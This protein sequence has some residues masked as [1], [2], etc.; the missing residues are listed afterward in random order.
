MSKSNDAMLDALRK[1]LE[2]KQQKSGGNNT[3]DYTKFYPFFNI[4]FDESV[5]LR[6]LQDKNQ[7]ILADEFWV[8]EQMY[9]W[10]FAHPTE[11]GQEVRVRIPCRNMYEERTDP[12]LKTLSQ[13]Y[14]QLKSQGKNLWVKKHY[15]YN[16][17]VKK[18]PIEE[19]NTPENPIRLFKLSK[20]LHGIIFNALMETDDDLK[21]PSIPI[22]LEEGLNFIISKKKNSG[23]Y[24]SYSASSFSAKPSSLTDDELAAIEQYGYWDLRAQLPAMPSDEAYGVLP[25][26]MEANINDEPWNMDWNEYFRPIGL[27]SGKPESEMT[28]NLEDVSD[29]D[30]SEEVEEKPVNTK[31]SDLIAKL[32]KKSAG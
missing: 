12:V 23:G 9:D 31:N 4:D 19:E 30:T 2:A 21:L 8:E 24:A 25:E 11:P 15:Y 5:T 29:D 18:S 22:D 6:F 32:K 10:K 7:E 27:N 28:K 26:I 13:K 14:D 16:G 17:F 20:D 1:K 3:A